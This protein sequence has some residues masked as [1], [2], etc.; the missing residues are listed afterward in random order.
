MCWSYTPCRD[1]IYICR[2]RLPLML[3]YQLY[4][5]TCVNPP[6]YIWIKPKNYHDKYF[7]WSV[8]AWSLFMLV[9]FPVEED[10]SLPLFVGSFFFFASLPAYL[11]DDFPLQPRLLTHGSFT[12][13]RFIKVCGAKLHKPKGPT[14]LYFAYFGTLLC[15]LL[16]ISFT[17]EIYKYVKLAVSNCKEH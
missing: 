2:V 7:R 12:P 15:L 9:S 11:C 14:L 10:R 4:T 17:C 16:F 1:W 13:S 8:A 5:V 3:N 6:S